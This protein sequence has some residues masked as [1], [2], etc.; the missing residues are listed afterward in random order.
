MANVVAAAQPGSAPVDR[1]AAFLQ[2][3]YSAARTEGFGEPSSGVRAARA[4]RVGSRSSGSR[5]ANQAGHLGTTTNGYR[6]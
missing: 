6:G 4:F 2:T 5:I 1:R 3:C